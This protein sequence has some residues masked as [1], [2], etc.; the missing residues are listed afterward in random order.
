MATERPLL[1]IIQPQ[2]MKSINVIVALA[3]AMLTLPAAAQRINVD[4]DL[5][6]NGAPSNAFGGYPNQPGFWNAVNPGSSS[7]PVTIG[8]LLDTNSVPTNVSLNWVTS[9]A[10]VSQP[11]GT[12]LPAG[13]ISR[14]FSDY[15]PPNANNY[16][17]IAGLN[18]G[19]YVLTLY[20]FRPS[21]ISPIYVSNLPPVGATPAP[22]SEFRCVVNPAQF[23]QLPFQPFSPATL[24]CNGSSNVA[25]FLVEVAPGEE[26]HIL[27]LCDS[28]GGTEPSSGSEPPGQWR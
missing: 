21:A 1:P 4:F 7:M 3:A 20:S 24:V 14:L 26:V 23:S 6:G 28:S 5:T 2:V 10:V 9:S 11:V 25:S 19:R 16:L 17:W 15:L 27:M 12:L 18:P 22:G 8:P 13:D